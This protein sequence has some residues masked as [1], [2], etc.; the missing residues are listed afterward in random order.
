MR[1]LLLAAMMCG[2]VTAAH[3]ADLSDLPI[4]RGS[5]T[6]GLSKSNRNWDGWYVGGQA[7]YSSANM[8]FSQSLTGLTNFIFRDSVLETPTSQLSAL[9][10]ANPQATGF[11]GFVGRNW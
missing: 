11:G 4:L 2:A 5:Y 6:E 1:R 3:A 7:G 10:R 9:G 8:D